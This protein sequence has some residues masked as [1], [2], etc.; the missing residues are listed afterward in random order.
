M[1]G[2]DTTDRT[3]LS[4]HHLPSAT[5][6]DYVFPNISFPP[7]TLSPPWAAYP[8]V[9]LRCRCSICIMS[10]PNS[11]SATQLSSLFILCI[12]KTISLLFLC[13]FGTT[14]TCLVLFPLIP[15]FLRLCL[16]EFQQIL[17]LAA[18]HLPW[19]AVP[20]SGR[21]IQAEAFSSK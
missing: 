11:P 20:K 10:N 19:S 1:G 6:Q 12:W 3:T 16:P 17:L 2:G 14:R 18:P 4:R 21:R 13:I 7:C 8:C 15:G 5:G 9:S